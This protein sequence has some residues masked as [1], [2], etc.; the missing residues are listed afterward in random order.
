MATNLSLDDKLIEAARKAGKHKTNRKT[1]GGTAVAES[2]QPMSSV[3]T[4]ISAKEGR[5]R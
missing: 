5:K 1:S 4:N 2:P 3:Q